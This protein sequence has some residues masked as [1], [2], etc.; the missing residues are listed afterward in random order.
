MATAASDRSADSPQP[1]RRSAKSGDALGSWLKP[2]R[3]WIVVVLSVLAALRVLVFSAA[4]PFWSNVD[5][6][7]HFDAVFKY[8]EGKLPRAET[9]HF[10]RNVAAMYVLYGSPEFFHERVPGQVALSPRQAI[11]RLAKPEVQHRVFGMTEL[12]NSESN[13]WPSYYLLA[14]GWFRLGRAAG[15]VGPALLYWLRFLS[16]PL[17]GLSVWVAWRYLRSAFPDDVFLQL[18]TPLL[19]AV[20]PQDVFYGINS[21]VL[22]PLIGVGVLVLALHMTRASCSAWWYLLT[23]IA[24]SVGIL[25]KAT[26]IMLG[27]PLLL[28]TATR[29]YARRGDGDPLAEMLKLALCWAAAVLPVGWWLV[30]NRQYVGDWFATR[31]KMDALGWQT[32]PLGNWFD[33]PLFSLSGSYTFLTE[34]AQTSWRGELIWGG[35]RLRSP[36]MDQFYIWSTAAC[37]LAA[38]VAL[39]LHRRESDRVERVANRM[40]LALVVSSVA[41]LA[42]LSLPFD[43]GPSHY[44]SAEHPYFTSGRLISAAL[45]PFCILYLQGMRFFLRPLGASVPYFGV[46]VLAA[47]LLG[48]EI[49]LSADVFRSPFNWYHLPS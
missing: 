2:Y 16:A 6:P 18:A 43:F 36:A 30:R 39:W 19:L 31:E 26:N 13:S 37:L 14:G 22:S 21:D 29:L 48:G 4:F 47:F 41:L 44:P 8:G 3:T 42:C 33:H 24:V 45:V 32:K 34:L 11:E 25:I 35:E 1:L 40:N 17:Y 12:V 38:A 49:Y 46:L 5:E 7:Q 10:D 9:S 23:G 15:L 28:A 27:V 20:F